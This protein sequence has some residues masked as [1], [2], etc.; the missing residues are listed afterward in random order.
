MHI[1]STSWPNSFHFW[2]IT[3]SR[4]NNKT[5]CTE[6]RRKWERKWLQKRIQQKRI[7]LSSVNDFNPLKKNK[8]KYDCMYKAVC[9]LVFVAECLIPYHS[10][11]DSSS[12]ISWQNENIPSCHKVIPIKSTLYIY[13]VSFH[14]RLRVMHNN[15]NHH[16]VLE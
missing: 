11:V 13:S 1:C 7:N 6:A 14:S 3:K 8:E 2:H 16:Q 12:F 10:L 9:A 4:K 15:D 5:Y